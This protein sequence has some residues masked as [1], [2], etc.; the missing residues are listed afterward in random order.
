MRSAGKLRAVG[1]G[2]GVG[3][4]MA[5]GCPSAGT[6]VCADDLSCD[7]IAGGGVCLSD[8]DCAYPDP[9]C[10][11]GLRRSPGASSAASECV[12]VEAS[13]TTS[14]KTTL[15]STSMVGT[16]SE[17]SSGTLPTCGERKALLLDTVHIPD[18]ATPYPLLVALD[19]PDIL[20]AGEEIWFAAGSGEVVPHEIEADPTDDTRVLVWLG[21][22]EVSVPDPV[23]VYVHYGDPSTAPVVLPR[24]VWGSHYLGV[25]HLDEPLTD[26]EGETVTD[27][28]IN[29]THGSALGGMGPDA[30]VQGAVGGALLLDGDDDV[31]EVPTPWAGKLVSFTVSVWARVDDNSTSPGALFDRLNGD[32]LY[33]RCRKS[34][35]DTS[36]NLFCQIRTDA[37]DLVT[38]SAS[39]SLTP[40]GTTF[41]AALRWDAD[42]GVVTIF[43]DGEPITTNDIVG[44]ELDFGDNDMRMGQVETFGGI[45]GLLDEFRL[46]N[47]ALSDAWLAA[48]YATQISPAANVLDVGAAEPAAC[49]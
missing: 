11:S 18:D 26:E 8:G 3:G 33:P 7:R 40:L 35:G 6:F 15:G 29:L 43:I 1:L 48:D 44:T 28:T 32:G 22:A 38:I 39:G 25:W 34:E 24:D 37:P 5:V 23:T 13:S 17:S 14:G 12:P 42:A 31:V 45:V 47:V 27:S 2:L 9:V 46:S 30:N 19:D 10:D 16:D 4:L 20:A 41:L 36:S 49:P 21:L